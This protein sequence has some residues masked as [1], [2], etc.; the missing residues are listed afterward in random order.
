MS[1][2]SFMPSSDNVNAMITGGGGDRWA[3]FSLKDLTL[4]GF[5]NMAT[6]GIAGNIKM[7]TS[8]KGDFSDQLKNAFSAGLDWSVRDVGLAKEVRSA[9]QKSVDAWN[10]KDPYKLFPLPESPN[11]ANM[12]ELRDKLI[13]E[14]ASAQHS[15]ANKVVKYIQ[16]IDD[17][18]AQ[19]DCER[20]L[21][22]Q[23]SY[24]QAE[25]SINVAKMGLGVD[26]QGSVSS[27]TPMSISLI[28]GSVLF[29]GVVAIILI[30]SGKS[31]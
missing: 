19:N 8:G 1:N 21:L 27:M 16:E 17:V 5:G 18:L 7:A 6:L 22:D 24:D 30:R 25:R 9:K 29:I 23:E 28:A 20:Q 15:Y 10:E 2:K 14:Q 4:E 12:K 31:E 13:L 3:N 11:C 26:T